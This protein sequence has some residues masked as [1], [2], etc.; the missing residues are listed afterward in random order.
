MVGQGEICLWQLLNQTYDGIYTGRRRKERE[1]RRQE[2]VI[3]A[4]L[5]YS[6]IFSGYGNL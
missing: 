3:N 2:K 6:L 1:K 4:L 5:M